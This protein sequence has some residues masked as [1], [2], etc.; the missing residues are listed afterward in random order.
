M[1][2]LKNK[3]KIDIRPLTK[4]DK[5]LFIK[6]FSEI[7]QERDVFPFYPDMTDSEIE[8]FMIQDNMNNYIA[9]YRGE[10]VGGYFL[11]NNFPGLADHIAVAGYMVNKNFRNL[12]LGKL[13]VKHSLAKARARGFKAM[14]FNCVVSNNSSV[15]LY[16]KLGFDIIGVIPEGYRH[17]TQGFIDLYIMH[18]IL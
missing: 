8:N 5:A 7:N 13:L 12:G 10:I 3:S 17:S 4:A 9:I 15:Y 6:L 11:K 2:T 18:R 1:H 14:Q 16:K